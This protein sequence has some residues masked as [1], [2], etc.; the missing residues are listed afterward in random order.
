LFNQRHDTWRALAR[1]L[2]AQAESAPSE[3]IRERLVEAGTWL[4]V[5]G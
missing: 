5:P 2:L 3:W 4:L 1:R